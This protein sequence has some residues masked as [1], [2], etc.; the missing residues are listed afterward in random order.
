MVSVRFKHETSSIWDVFTDLDAEYARDASQENAD[1]IAAAVEEHGESAWYE[2]ESDVRVEDYSFFF[3][4]QFKDKVKINWIFLEILD[5]F[6]QDYVV[7]YVKTVLPDLDHDQKVTVLLRLQYPAHD[8]HSVEDNEVY[9]DAV[10]RVVMDA[11]KKEGEGKKKRY[12]YYPYDVVVKSF[13]DDLKSS[14]LFKENRNDLPEQF[15]ADTTSNFIEY[16]KSHWDKAPHLASVY[17]RLSDVLPE[18][19]IT[20]VMNAL[21]KGTTQDVAEKFFTC[22]RD[23]PE[24]GQ[25]PVE[26]LMKLHWEETY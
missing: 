15:W 3:W 17:K 2:K 19:H 24:I 13:F 21:L 7:Q 4:M 5:D 12:P 25:Y 26:W 11:W 16:P 14:R 10:Y 18:Q 8:I 23:D 1:A 9:S 6:P 20:V 22:L